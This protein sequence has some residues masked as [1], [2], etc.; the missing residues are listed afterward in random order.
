MAGRSKKLNRQTLPGNGFLPRFPSGL[1]VH[2]TEKD[3]VGCHPFASAR[4]HFFFFIPRRWNRLPV[5]FP[6]LIHIACPHTSF[7]TH[8]FFVGPPLSRLPSTLVSPVLLDYFVVIFLPCRHVRTVPMPRCPGRAR[9]S[10]PFIFIPNISTKPR[11]ITRSPQPFRDFHYY[12]F[13]SLIRRPTSGSVIAP[14][15]QHFHKTSGNR[16]FFMTHDTP[17]ISRPTLVNRI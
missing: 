8:H 4:K 16:T 10:L 6:D 12:Y 15:S 1:G 5:S 7:L 17:A 9:Y 2:G 13:L 11:H 14:V 3:P